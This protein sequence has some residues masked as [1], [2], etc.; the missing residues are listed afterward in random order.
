M[1]VTLD[2]DGVENIR[3]E[4]IGVRM[5][6]GKQRLVQSSPSCLWWLR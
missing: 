2:R 3:N 1:P 6:D 5:A 4:E